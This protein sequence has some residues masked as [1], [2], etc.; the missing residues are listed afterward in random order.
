[1]TL[2]HAPNGTP[3]IGIAGW[4]NSGKT[5]LAERLVAEFTRRG[6]RV[7]TVK[8]AHHSFEVDTA[9]TDSARHRSAGAAQVAIVSEKRWALMTELG[10]RAEPSL[11]EMIAM[12]AP[13]DL[14]LVEGYKS[15]PIRKIEVR[16]ASSAKGARLA[17]SDPHVIAIA[18]DD[19][20]THRGRLP[21]F[22]LDQ[23]DEIVD[24]IFDNS[25]WPDS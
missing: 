12:L 9:D 4:K 16:R 21:V 8:H 13:C 7:A 22:H 24:H 2:T 10:D 5:T 17:D 1:M 20:D 11:A 15:E 25:V 19:P 18:A 23:I 3:I 14:I 6:L